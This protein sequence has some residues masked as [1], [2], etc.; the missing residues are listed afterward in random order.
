M[1]NPDTAQ[2]R[3]ILQL[4]DLRR[5]HPATKKHIWSL[6]IAYQWAATLKAEIMNRGC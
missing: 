4:Q 3:A 2:V 6:M 5:H 1:P